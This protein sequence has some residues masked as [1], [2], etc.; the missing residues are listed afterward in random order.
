[1]L[2][3]TGFDEPRLLAL[4]GAG[5]AREEMGGLQLRACCWLG[6]DNCAR[7]GVAE[8][9]GLRGDAAALDARDDGV[10]LRALGRRERFLG[11]FCSLVRF[12][13]I[14][15]ALTVHDD[16]RLGRHAH[17]HARGSG[18]ASPDCSNKLSSH[19]YLLMP[20]A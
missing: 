9:A 18:L 4:F 16:R 11:N 5:V 2:T 13:I 14:F 3:L 15:D 12:K 1:M 17:A 20:S 6:F 8:R 7:D 19:V 10:V